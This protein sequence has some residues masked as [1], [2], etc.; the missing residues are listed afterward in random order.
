MHRNNQRFAYFST[1]VFS[2]AFCKKLYMK[3]VTYMYCSNCGKQISSNINFCPVCGHPISNTT[4]PT[5]NAEQSTLVRTLENYISSLLK[6]NLNTCIVGMIMLTINIVVYAILIFGE[7]LDVSIDAEEISYIIIIAIITMFVLAELRM[8]SLRYNIKK[9]SVLLKEQPRQAINLIA[10]NKW[11]FK[12]CI[13]SG[14]TAMM[15]SAFFAF[16][17]ILGLIN[18]FSI[19]KYYDEGAALLMY[20]R[21]INGGF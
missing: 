10:Q 4:P 8:L 11:R 3:G 5:F 13:G 14:E 20:C 17:P 6:S 18:V 15:L 7:M 1:T 19:K 21:N 16:P 12:V 2:I 9:I